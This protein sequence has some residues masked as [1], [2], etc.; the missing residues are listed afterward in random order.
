MKSL[1]IVG[2]G[3]FLGGALRY[4]VSVL[5][6]NCT[7]ASFPY[8]TLTVNLAGCFLLGLLFALFGK[9]GYVTSSWSLFLATGFCGGFTTYS[10]FANESLQM[11]QTGNIRGFICYVAVSVVA[12]LLLAALGYW[13]VK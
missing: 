11:I 3:S 5:M 12:G 7:A 13:I 4:M 10:T 9:Y 8:A 1:L 2:A 6:K